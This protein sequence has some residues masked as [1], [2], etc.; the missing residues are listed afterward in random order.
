MI[1]RTLPANPGKDTCP[2]RP[3]TARSAALTWAS[4]CSSGRLDKILS[5]LNLRIRRSAAADL[6]GADLTG[7]HLTRAHLTRAN[8]TRAN[9][10]RA[11]LTSADLTRA[12]ITGTNLRGARLFRADLG[13]ADLRAA[14]LG[15]AD[16]TG[17]LWSDKTHWPEAVAKAMRARSEELRPGVWRVV[18]S[19]SAD[20]EVDK[21]RMPV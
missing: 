10:T 20:A 21:P 9:L 5:R 15:G 6:T 1:T 2:V 3:K 18:G 11:N 16:L 14:D 13:G 17:V 12:L 4:Q 7:A 8:L 19:G